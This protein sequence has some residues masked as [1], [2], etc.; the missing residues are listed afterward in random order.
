MII[1]KTFKY[2]IIKFIENIP[3]LQI[4]IYN[5]VSKFK[6]LFPHEKD[7]FALKL[8]FDEDEKRDFL[9]VGGNIGLSTIG[10]RELGFKKNS[11]HIF[12]PDAF[13][14]NN[15]INKLKKLYK[16]IKIYKFGLYSKDCDKKLIKAYFKN[17]YFHFNNSF[18]KKYI[19]NKIKQNYPK[20]F[21]SF[22]YKS[23]KLKLKRYDK[24]NLKNNICFVKI[25]VEGLDHEVIKGMKKLL[26]KYRPVIL[27]EYNFS[28]FKIIYNLVKI[29]YKCYQF[30]M[31][32]NKLKKLSDKEINLLISGKTLEKKYS[33]NSV[34]IFYIHKNNQFNLK[35]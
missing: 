28:N 32:Q 35:K 5:N 33:K 30:D 12:E 15:Y 27:V 29:N 21:A 19:K 18:D 34:N 25:D 23:Q 22:R 17:H 6:F 1:L 3:K 9:D 31:D 4:F 14:V 13:L 24:L 2:Q 10:F 26:A 20:K 7:Y 16:N 8:L 11:I